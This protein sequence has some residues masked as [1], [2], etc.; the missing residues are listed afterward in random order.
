MTDSNDATVK[1]ERLTDALAAEI[2]NLS[3]EELLK[4][5]AEE[6]G[7]VQAII[8]DMQGV[9]GAAVAAH[10][11]TR[12][13]RARAA[14][15]AHQSQDT[16]VLTLSLT[17]K[18]KIIES[19]ASSDHEFEERLTL[20]AR[21]STDPNADIDNILEDLIALGVIDEKGNRR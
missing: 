18:R 16:P 5:A 7:G 12:L 10:G 19:F 21:N 11:K 1:F 14:L 2:D 4:E 17:Q 13:A 6:D 20:A 8:N 15:Q 9:I 3:D